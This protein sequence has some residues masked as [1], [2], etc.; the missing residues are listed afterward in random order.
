[1]NKIVKFTLSILYSYLRYEVQFRFHSNSNSV[2]RL[3]LPSLHIVVLT[4]SSIYLQIRR[5]LP[6]LRLYYGLVRL[7]VNHQISSL[8]GRDI[9]LF[10]QLL[11]VCYCRKRQVPRFTRLQSLQD[12]PSSCSFL[13]IS[14]H[15]LRPRKSNLSLTTLRYKSCCL[16]AHENCRPL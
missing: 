14:Y 9:L 8:F 3:W 10:L 2:I 13:A 7:P 11:S 12:L 15:G 16:P 5:A 1:M 6:L 4:P